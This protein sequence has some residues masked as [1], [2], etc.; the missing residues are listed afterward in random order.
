MM[1]DEDHTTTQKCPCFGTTNCKKQKHLLYGNLDRT[2]T[3]YCDVC[4]CDLWLKRISDSGFSSCHFIFIS[5]VVLGVGLAYLYES[6]GLVL[7]CV[8][9]YRE[10]WCMFANSIIVSI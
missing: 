5:M 1:Q 7:Y 6:F 4:H 2:P 9:A 10:K 8:L 3:S